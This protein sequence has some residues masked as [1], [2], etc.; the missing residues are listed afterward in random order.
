VEIMHVSSADLTRKNLST[1]ETRYRTVMYEMY[2]EQIVPKALSVPRLLMDAA[3][4]V[5]GIEEA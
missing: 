3:L 1:G 5:G 2:P 4:K